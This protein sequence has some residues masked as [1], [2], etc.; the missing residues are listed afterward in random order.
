MDLEKYATACEEAARPH[1]VKADIHPDDFIFRFLFNNT[2]FPTKE[3]AI[4]YYFNDGRGSANKLLGLLNDVCGYDGGREISVLE[5]A[6]GYGCVTRHLKDVMPFAKTTAC[7]IHEQAVKFIR[8]RLDGDAVLSASRPEDL[9]LG[10]TYDVVFAL[11][12]FSHMPKTTS[13]RWMSQL[14]S[15]VKPG[16][17][18]IFT[19]HGFKSLKNF[20]D[21]V[22][23]EEGFFFRPSSEQK[24]LD[25]SEYGQT[26]VMPQYVFSRAFEIQ[27]LASAYFRE[28]YWWNHQ[29]TYVFRKMLAGEGAGQWKG[30]IEVKKNLG[31]IRRLFKG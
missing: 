3:S 20:P 15:H 17:H 25:V 10:Q 1:N 21:C 16:G 13:S 29:D 12:F 9:R 27:G 11:S 31:W 4:S 6:S 26:C 28:G 2:C 22:F 30:V 8:E 24:D 19:T 18:L 14:A 7:D 23:D 5:F